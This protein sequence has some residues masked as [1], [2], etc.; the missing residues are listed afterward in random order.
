MNRTRLV[1]NAFAL[2]ALSLAFTTAARA[3]GARS[4]V[5]A[6]GSD[7]KQCTRANP[8]RSF[9]GALA[10]TDAGGEIIA[11]DSGTYAATTVTKSITLAAAPGADVGITVA[12]GNAVTVN[13]GTGDTVVLRG[14]TLTGPGVGVA[15]SSGVEVV[16]G[17]S[18]VGQELYVERCIISNFARG[19][20]F[21]MNGVAGKLFVSDT[22]VRGNGYGMHIHAT[23]SDLHFHGAS[24]SHS[25]ME[26][27][28]VGIGANSHVTIHDS[29]AAGNSESG[30]EVIGGVMSITNCVAT[31]NRKG[32]EASGGNAMLGSSTITGNRYGLFVSPGG[33]ISSMGNNMVAGNDDG[34][35]LGA[36][37]IVPIAAK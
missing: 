21:E 7:T 34:D 10:K 31:K 18:G 3:D 4:Y 12:S 17:L 24:V 37:S 27:N 26:K 23:T 14:L 9:D 35:I 13:A 25:R 15:G 28:N 2:L 11:L 29:I 8:C 5:S 20:N 1:I 36:T 16:A 22:V 32:V 30:F 19:I 33:L 6:G